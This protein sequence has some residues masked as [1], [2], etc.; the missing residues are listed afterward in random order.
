MVL[1]VSKT[2]MKLKDLIL[3][4]KTLIDQVEKM[5]AIN[6]H[7]CTRVNKHEDKLLNITDEL[8]KT[9]TF[10]STLKQQH[11]Q[12]HE[13]EQILR[14]ELTEKRHLLAKLRKELEYSRESW[15]VVKK[16]TADS[17]REWHALRAEFAARRKLFKSAYL[18]GRVSKNVRKRYYFAKLALFHRRLFI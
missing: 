2:F 4:K 13:S 6:A 17:E 15:N 3:E 14:A 18:L 1:S 16:K 7:L 5:K 12:L 8:N 10:V 11:R 9:W